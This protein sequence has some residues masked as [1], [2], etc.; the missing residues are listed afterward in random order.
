MSAP[1]ETI[2]RSTEQDLRCVARWCALFGTL[3]VG[4]AGGSARAETLAQSVEVNA[5]PAIVWALIG[6]YCAIET[7]LPPIGSCR[8]DGQSPPTRTLVTRDRS[9]TFVEQETERSDQGHFYSYT[10]VSSP[11]PVHNYR[12]T[13]RV[14]AR[15]TGGS[16]IV[17]KGEYVPDVG[18]EQ[19]AHDAL[20][21]V[22]Q[23]GLDSI[24]SHFP[25]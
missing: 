8:L 3:L 16:T 6:P 18:R 9:A 4:T 23:A 17:W 7:W 25:R 2:M 10:F 5:S 1:Q 22:Y 13:I 11:L 20:A 24:A 12:S 21:E 15:G 14:M 19:Q